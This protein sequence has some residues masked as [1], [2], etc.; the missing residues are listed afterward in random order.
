MPSIHAPGVYV[1]EEKGGARPIEAVGTSVAGFVGKAPDINAHQ[2]QAMLVVNWS[3][4][5]LEFAKKSTVSTSL[6]HAVY[7]F[8]LQGGSQCYIVN[9]GQNTSLKGEEG[10]KRQGLDVLQEIDQIAMV[11]APGFS[12]VADY[13][14]LLTHCENLKDR[15]AILD[16][17]QVVERLDSLLGVALDGEEGGGRARE[18]EDGYGAYYFPWLKVKDPFDG[19]IA[20]VPPSGHVAGIWARTDASRGV[21]KAPANEMIRGAMNVVYSITRAEQELLNPKGVNC[22]RFFNSSG[23][24]IWGARTLANSSSEWRYINVRRLTNMIK[25][26]IQESTHW[27]VFEPNTISL[28]KSIRRD[29]SAFLT[30]LWRD[31]ALMGATPNEAFFVQ[32]DEE[33]NPKENI[34]NGIVTV[35]IGFAPAKPA[36]FVVFKISQYDSG[37]ETEKEGEE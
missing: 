12:S 27:V 36:E 35:R 25:E 33:T 2:H 37:T 6:S 31:G 5:C 4:F 3:Q 26:S 13:D 14:D 32:C 29:I 17:P 10:G 34:D 8:F 24:K 16:S 22:I 7:G 11:A 20:T 23:I 9:I 18:S 15:V 30:I 1:Y 19:S 28:W 21:H